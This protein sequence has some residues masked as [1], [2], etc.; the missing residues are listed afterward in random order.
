MRIEGS[1]LRSRDVEYQGSL[2][3][4]LEEYV[5]K[6]EDG[7]FKIFVD[8][9]FKWEEVVEAHNYLET[10]SSMGKVICTID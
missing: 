7:T 1:T 9:V 3:N 4:K 8:K 6:F 5:E 10:N 2:R